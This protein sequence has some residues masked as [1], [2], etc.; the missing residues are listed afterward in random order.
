M[1]LIGRYLFDSFKTPLPWAQCQPT[2]AN[3][4]DSSGNSTLDNVSGLV[5]QS[6]L[7]PVIYGADGQPQQLVSSSEYYFLY[8]N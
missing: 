8:V 1:A 3:C 4:I 7:N 6:S 2:W 5:Q